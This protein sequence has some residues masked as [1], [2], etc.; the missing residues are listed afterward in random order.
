MPGEREEASIRI[1]LDHPVNPWEHQGAGSIWWGAN[2]DRLAP[3]AEEVVS[4]IREAWEQRGEGIHDRG[5]REREESEPVEREPAA[6]L[7]IAPGWAARI[8]PNQYWIRLTLYRP[9]NPRWEEQEGEEL[10]AR[11]A[12]QRWDPRARRD[13]RGDHAP[14]STGAA[15]HRGVTRPSS[16]RRA[17]APGAQCLVSVGRVLLCPK[18]NFSA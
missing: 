6:G 2:L 17:R 11:T 13:R 9:V 8:E 15:D 16:V 1:V 10:G 14:W 7:S 3:L 18:P 5:R 12:R 4:I